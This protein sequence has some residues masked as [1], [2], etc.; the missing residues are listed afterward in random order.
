MT[1]GETTPTRGLPPHRPA[2]DSRHQKLLGGVVLFL[3]CILQM[4]IFPLE[5]QISNFISPNTAGCRAQSTT[6]TSYYPSLNKTAETSTTSTAVATT[7]TTTTTT[8]TNTTTYTTP[9]LN[10][11]AAL[12]WIMSF[13]LGCE[14]SSV[15]GREHVLEQLRNK[16]ILFIGDSIL[17]Y[18]FR[19]H[20]STR[21]I[22]DIPTSRGKGIVLTPV[23][24]MGQTLVRSIG[25]FSR[26]KTIL[27]R[28]ISNVIAFA[29]TP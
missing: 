25:S 24:C 20:C 29:T 18:Q 16:H 1:L 19:E 7:T 27:P 9:S 23:K 10:A 3:C 17:R 22:L 2:R 13:S 8:T 28:D 5:Y 26:C 4:L 11:T 12:E 14:F 6:T 21:S 15:G